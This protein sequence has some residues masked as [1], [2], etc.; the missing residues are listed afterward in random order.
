MSKK[1]EITE[2]QARHIID[3]Y[4]Y[5]KGSKTYTDLIQS[6]ERQIDLRRLYSICLTDHDERR[7]LL[8]GAQADRLDKVIYLMLDTFNKENSEDEK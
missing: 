2:K 5:L 1:I 3:V 6:L 4:P 7:Q 8:T